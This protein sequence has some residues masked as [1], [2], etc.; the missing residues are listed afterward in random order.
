M[1]ICPAAA[2]CSLRVIRLLVLLI[3]AVLFVLVARL[4]TEPVPSGTQRDFVTEL[5]LREIPEIFERFS[6]IVGSDVWERRIRQLNAEIRHNP[7]IEH[8]VRREYMVAYALERCGEL[9]QRREYF[10]E[11]GPDTSDFYQ[12]LGFAR[13][14][15]GMTDQATP[16][17]AQRMISRVRDAVVNPPAMRGLRLELAVATHFA[18]RGH[19]LAWPEMIGAGTFDLLLPELGTDGLEIE[20]K[21]ISNDKGR[22]VHRREVLALL[23]QIQPLV[24]PICAT[25][26][27]DLIVVVSVLQRLPTSKEALL[28]IANRVRNQIWLS[29]TSQ[30]IDGYSVDV[31]QLDAGTLR[32]AMTPPGD[33][34]AAISKVIGP[35]HREAMVFDA[36][37]SGGALAV[38]I[39]G[40]RADDM[41]GATFETLRQAAKRQLTQS[42]A[43]LLVAGFEDLSTTQLVGIAEQENDPQRPPTALGPHVHRLLAEPQ[44]N[45]VI[46]VALLS[47]SE[48]L[49]HAGQVVD[50][51]GAS[52]SFLNRSSR[53]WKLDFEGM[54]GER[55]E[56]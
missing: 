28:A 29:Q 26:K 49:S 24:R 36:R 1:K 51:A 18:R 9:L 11:P 3:P 6:A 33:M 30:F 5:S 8:H 16:L 39:Q 37:E 10:P 22:S 44:R 32:A 31:F 21:S 41:L 4:L 52:F 56:P 53:Y 7:L 25:L 38:V 19:R 42:R 50:T 23:Q 55:R 46:G 12:A 27:V 43:G 20:C 45:H 47:R 35:G 17:E 15:L 14:V 54:F 40:V 48:L 34:R 13:Q 2:A